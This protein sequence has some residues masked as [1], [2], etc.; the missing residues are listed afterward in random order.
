MEIGAVPGRWTVLSENPTDRRKVSIKTEVTHI[1]YDTDMQP[2]WTSI[3]SADDLRRR[4][5]RA[6]GQ[7]LDLYIVEDLSRMVIEGLGSRFGIDPYF[8]REQLTDDAHSTL[9]EHEDTTPNLT[10]NHRRRSWFRIRNVRI[11][12]HVPAGHGPWDFPM[13][14][15]T[16][17]NIERSGFCETE[18]QLYHEQLRMHV[19]L[20][21]SR[22]TVWIGQE[23]QGPDGV[24]GIVLVDPRGCESP[25]W[26][27]RANWLPVP[28][29]RDKLSRTL[30]L[31]KTVS[32]Y[33]DICQATAHYPWFKS[34][35]AIDTTDPCVIVLPAFYTICAEWLLVCK[36]AELR[37]RMINR[38]LEGGATG[39]DYETQISRGLRGLRSWHDRVG[40]WK[41]MVQETLDQA[42]PTAVRLTSTAAC[43]PTDDKFEDI[44]YDFNRVLRSLDEV[45]HRLDQLE[46]RA[47]AQMQLLAARDSL[48]ESH[49]LARLTWLAT[50]FVP[51][52]FISGLFSMTDDLRS[53]RGTFKI[54]FIVAI[55]VAMLLTVSVRWGSSAF[56]HVT[57]CILALCTRPKLKI[58]KREFAR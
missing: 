21:V 38:L 26:S 6:H 5:E 13:N 47:G 30:W 35:A 24:V 15:I 42:L 55:P 41:K 40:D 23:R 3:K 27:G 54:Y 43:S 22:T 10:A 51:L 9:E 19:S 52:T 34:S 46:Q 31:R 37:L 29:F 56:R 20:D 25:L 2:N 45:Q 16:N 8:F 58:I 1:H 11:Q 28:D 17:S 50:I 49:N 39:E 18:E 36:Y 57:Q 7:P 53:I 14:H 32:W 44:V 12:Y 48:A 33:D 4:L